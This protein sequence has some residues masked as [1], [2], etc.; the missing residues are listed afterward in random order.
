M[1]ELITGTKLNA[2]EL[3]DWFGITP[4]TFLHS[5]KQKLNELADF[6]KFE[7][8]ETKTGRFSSVHIIEVYEATYI[9]NPLKKEFLTWI[10][11]GG[12]EKVAAQTPDGVYSYPVVVNYYC[13]THGIPYD[14]PHYENV[15]Q[16]GIGDDGYRLK[17]GK[18]KTPNEEFHEWHYLYRLLR[19]Y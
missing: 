1:N 2:K 16:N 15:L 6:C 8:K 3:A 4:T 14:G 13:A 9:R 19:K 7:I 12:I 18:R 17:D 5:K 10:E 11:N